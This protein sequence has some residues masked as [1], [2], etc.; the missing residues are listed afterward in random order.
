M[1]FY[2]LADAF[3]KYVAATSHAKS[4]LKQWTA[5]K[6]DFTGQAG[7][8]LLALLALNDPELPDAFFA[9]YLKTIEFGIHKAPNRTR[10]AMNHALIAIGT[11]NPDLTEAALKIAGK[12][13]KVEVDHGE[14]GCVTPDA[15]AYIQKTL[16]RRAKK[17]AKEKAGAKSS[18][19]SAATRPAAKHTKAKHTKAKKRLRTRPQP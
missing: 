10:H 17:L 3:S 18:P 15:T 6:H 16:A 19:R 5:S 7:W 12:I 8:N 11:R 14:T 13:G 4:K 9:P 2:P 1:D